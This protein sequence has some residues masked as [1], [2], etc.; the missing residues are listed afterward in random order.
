[1]MSSSGSG[2]G[3]GE[4]VLSIGILGAGVGDVLDPAPELA[5]SRLGFIGYPGIET[6]KKNTSHHR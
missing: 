5:A 3:P 4:G 2:D 6:I 1:M